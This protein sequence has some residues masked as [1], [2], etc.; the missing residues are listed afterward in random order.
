[1]QNFIKSL[2]LF[3]GLS[4]SVDAFGFTL[5]GGTSATKGWSSNTIEFHINPADCPGN[6]R[7]MVEEAFAVWNAIPTVSL[8]LKIGSDSAVTIEQVLA[9]TIDATPS[10]H[11]VTNMA[12]IGLNPSVI[13]GVAMG[14]RFDGNSHI[15]MAALVLNVQEGASANI[16]NLD[17]QLTIDVITHE[18]G[19]VLGLG[20]SGDTNALMYYDA[21]ARKSATLAQDDVDGMTYLYARDELG[22]DQMF[23]GCSVI[24]V[25]SH[26]LSSRWSMVLLMLPLFALGVRSLRRAAS[27]RHHRFS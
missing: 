15:V 21:S 8:D 20:H 14:M 23:G 24:G 7:S 19:H 6:V 16:N 2:F 5:L 9:G 17:S 12:A 1:M 26:K 27:T 3:V 25:Q 11:C 18:I 10:I 4:A 13:P 22:P